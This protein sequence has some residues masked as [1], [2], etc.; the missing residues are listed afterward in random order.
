MP[1]RSCCMIEQAR[2]TAREQINGQQWQGNLNVPSPGKEDSHVPTD[3][4]SRLRVDE[5]L[6]TA[7]E[8]RKVT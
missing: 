3:Q 4:P 8:R 1:P 2:G 6:P 7:A 5:D